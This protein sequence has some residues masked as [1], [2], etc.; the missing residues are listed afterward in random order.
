MSLQ[1]AH[2]RSR[3]RSFHRAEP[4]PE[5]GDARPGLLKAAITPAVRPIAIWPGDAAHAEHRGLEPM[6]NLRDRAIAMLSY[7]HSD[8]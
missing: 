7:L 3:L 2:G 8:T 4:A 5:Q 1:G 6:E